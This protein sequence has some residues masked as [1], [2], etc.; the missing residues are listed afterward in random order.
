MFV[1][2]ILRALALIG[3]AQVASSILKSKPTY[4]AVGDI[5]TLPYADELGL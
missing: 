2:P 3:R 1:Y 5:K 4:V